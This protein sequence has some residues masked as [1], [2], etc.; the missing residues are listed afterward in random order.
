MGKGS[1]RRPFDER[2]CDPSKFSQRWEEIF[3]KKEEDMSDEKIKTNQGLDEVK[4]SLGKGPEKEKTDG[5][6][7]VKVQA[8]EQTFNK[9]FL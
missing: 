1:D 5:E 7:P 3:A 8:S 2:Y 6:Q 4:K 9:R